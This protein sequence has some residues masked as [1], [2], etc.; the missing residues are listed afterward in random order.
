MEFS[1][2]LRSL[3]VVI[4]TFFF[5]RI[6]FLNNSNS[7]LEEY[8]KV[9]VIIPAR[10]EEGNI[11]ELIKCLQSQTYKNFEII[12]VDDESMDN[13]LKVAKNL[14]VK[15]VSSRPDAGW[16]G[17]NKACYEG[18]LNSDGEILVFMDADVRIRENV[19]KTTVVNILKNPSI[20]SI[21]PYMLIKN[22]LERLSLVFY[23]IG[24]FSL[25]GFRKTEGM[26]GAYF[27]I[28]REDYEKIGGHSAIKS[29]VLDDI[30]L[31]K[32]ASKSGIQVRNLLAYK[33]VS[34]YMYPGGIKDIITGWSRNFPLGARAISLPSFFLVF[35]WVS[36]LISSGL[37]LPLHLLFPEQFRFNF[38]DFVFYI[39]FAIQTILVSRRLGDFGF[40][41]PILHF[42]PSIFFAFLFI[43]STLKIAIAR[44]VVW[45]G[46]EVSIMGENE[47]QSQ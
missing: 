22:K 37:N 2:F 28:R 19:L 10:N 6:R 14:G 9:S 25:L 26:F 30:S 20:I 32:L 24:C 8:P 47:C 5:L 33:T 13:T 7:E 21:Q 4:G 17:K 29:D 41:I 34:A 43:I 18:Y 42:I 27:A 1:D 36:G 40:L 15:V 39:I 3:A 35:I 12:V 16:T 11:P 23:V 31:A 38:T 45:K 44:K 46:R